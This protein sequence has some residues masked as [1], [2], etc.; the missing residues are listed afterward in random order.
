MATDR[1]I[2]GSAPFAALVVDANGSVVGA[3]VNRVADLSDPT[4]H[5]EIEA[6][7]DAATGLG[8]TSL[9]GHAVIASG[10]PCA[11]CAMALRNGGVDVVYFAMSR[12]QAAMA[13]YDYRPSYRVLDEPELGRDMP[14][15]YHP[16]PEMDLP[17][18]N[19]T[20]LSER[21]FG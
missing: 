6:L 14:S 12:D 21:N 8:Q 15:Y 10:E 1:A 5:A 16:A 17:P 9:R 3:G 18:E 4:A 13:G 7:R 19:E 2:A 20:G 11:M